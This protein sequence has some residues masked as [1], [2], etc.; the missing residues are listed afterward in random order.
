MS[1]FTAMKSTLR[2]PTL[3][4][5]LTALPPHPPAPITFILAPGSGVLTNSIITDPPTPPTGKVCCPVKLFSRFLGDI[6]KEVSYP[7]AKSRAQPSQPAR[8][9]YSISNSAH[10]AL[11]QQQA[12][13]GGV[14]RLHQF[15]GQAFQVD[16]K[17]APHRHAED[18]LGQFL[19]A[20]EQRSPSHQH[21]AR[22]EAVR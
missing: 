18:T 16:R 6:S 7:I 10:R 20:L 5:W 9:S 13:R 11:M 8:L 1:V 4:M 14:H 22:R 17:S 3:I 12:G 15:F 19:R 2:S 21:D